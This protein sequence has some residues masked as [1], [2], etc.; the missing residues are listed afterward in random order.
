MA[1][2]GMLYGWRR[3]QSGWKEVISLER[4]SLRGVTRLAVSPRGDYLA[5]VGLPRQSR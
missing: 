3:G 1:H 4:L 2:G 5:L